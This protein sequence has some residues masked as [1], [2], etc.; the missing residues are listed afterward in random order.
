M[1]DP[2]TQLAFIAMVVTMLIVPW[3]AFMAILNRKLMWTVTAFAAIMWYLYSVVF[4]A[5]TDPSLYVYV[6]IA[7]ILF[8]VYSVAVGWVMSESGSD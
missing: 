4:I 8:A 7:N 6:V 2:N 1:S 5:A 3:A